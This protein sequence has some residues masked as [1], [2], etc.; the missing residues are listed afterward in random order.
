MTGATVLGACLHA[1]RSLPHASASSSGL[2]APDFFGS[3]FRALDINAPWLEAPRSMPLEGVPDAETP[4]ELLD[5]E[6]IARARKA[7]ANCVPHQ[8][9]VFLEL[10]RC[11]ASPMTGVEGL[12]LRRGVCRPDVLPQEYFREDPE[13]PCDYIRATCTLRRGFFLLYGHLLLRTLARR[14]EALISAIFD[15]DSADERMRR[16]RAIVRRPA[17]MDE[18]CWRTLSTSAVLFVGSQTFRQSF[19][20]RSGRDSLPSLNLRGAGAPTRLCRDL[21]EEEFGVAAEIALPAPL[22]LILHLTLDDRSESPA[23][24]LLPKSLH[25]RAHILCDEQRVDRVARMLAIDQCGAWLPVRFTR[26]ELWNGT[27]KPSS[28]YTNFAGFCL[29]LEFLLDQDL[30]AIELPTRPAA[31]NAMAQEEDLAVHQQI[32][33]LGAEIAKEIGD[34][35][36]ARTKRIGTRFL[37]GMPHSD[38]E[39]SSDGF[40]TLTFGRLSGASRP[41]ICKVQQRA[42]GPVPI[43][44][45]LVPIPRHLV[46]GKLS[47]EFHVF[48][49]ELVSGGQPPWRMTRLTAN[50][51]DH[52][53][54]DAGALF[55]IELE[56]PA[57]AEGRFHTHAS[58]RM[59]GVPG[60]SPDAR[61]C[62]VIACVEAN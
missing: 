10:L 48:R 46:R 36:P 32:A 40:A 49:F 31:E 23:L 6:E 21:Y 27:T 1:V 17:G 53:I 4:F 50:A 28:L 16:L 38:F 55:C 29:A 9:L 24:A 15:V 54:V 14:D 12:R 26:Q 43:G 37:A 5:W 62:C 19:L 51:T 56:D 20:G 13:Q 61:L 7:G 39:F 44:A 8:L 60:E 18:K 22:A 2:P 33:A 25:E 52:F 45:I 11:I 59:T 42:A 35:G 3:P 58:M 47:V 34:A 41:L 30:A 57:F